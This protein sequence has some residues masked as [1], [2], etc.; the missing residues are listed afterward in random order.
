MKT[1]L[2]QK[3][4][5]PQRRFGHSKNR[6]QVLESSWNLMAHGDAREGKWRGNWRM[7]WVA[8]TLTLHRNVG[9]PAL[10][11]LMRTSRLPGSRQN[12]HPRR[13]KWTLRFA[14]RRNLV[15]ARVPS[16]FKRSLQQYVSSCRQHHVFKIRWTFT[17]GLWWHKYGRDIPAGMWNLQP[18][19]LLFTS[20]W[21][22]TK[23]AQKYLFPDFFGTY[24]K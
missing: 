22:G 14:K 1:S 10:L 16:R 18:T 7:E 2:I 9:Y 6:S 23:Q 17:P 21:R 8:S 12:W 24:R 13:F 15:S 19:L 4:L 5:K 3:L 20:E 11:P